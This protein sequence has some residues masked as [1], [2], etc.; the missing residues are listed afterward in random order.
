MSLLFT[1]RHQL[2]PPVL[3]RI[4]DLKKVEKGPGFFNKCSCCLLCDCSDRSALNSYFQ[5]LPTTY[6]PPTIH[7]PSTYRPPTDHL[8]TTYRPPNHRPLTDH[9]PTTYRPHTDHIPT[10][11]RPL[12]DHIPTSYR[13]HTDHLPTTFFTVQL[14]HNYQHGL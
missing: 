14:V 8:P 6:R 10:T 13:P 3:S 9:I 7:L 5:N 12:T 4:F 2:T 11:Y 1:V